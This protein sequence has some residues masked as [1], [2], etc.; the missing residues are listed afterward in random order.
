MA[1]SWLEV[2]DSSSMQTDIIIDSSNE[3]DRASLSCHVTRFDTTPC[4]RAALERQCRTCESRW[5]GGRGSCRIASCCVVLRRAVSCRA[6]SCRVVSWRGVAWR[7]VP[8][9]VVSWCGVAWYGV[10]WY[11][12]ELNGN[13]NHG[14]GLAGKQ[15]CALEVVLTLDGDRPPVP[16][17]ARGFA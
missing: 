4:D 13:G 15:Q 11:D 14:T 6:V 12:M 17:L 3:M 9:C 7:G 5:I 1:G 16:S 8:W 10:V 2:I